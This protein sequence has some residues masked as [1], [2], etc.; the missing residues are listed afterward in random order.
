MKLV[1]SD[2][3][4]EDYQHWVETDRNT[5]DRLNGLI[6]EGQRTPFT[7]TG[8]PEP[9]KGDLK[10]WWSRRITLTDRLVYRVEGRPNLDQRLEIAQCRFHYE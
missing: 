2:A 6:K 10:G 3:A 9:L 5:L 7:G 4:C 8:K 1:F